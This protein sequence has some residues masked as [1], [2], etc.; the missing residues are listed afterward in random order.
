[1]LASAFLVGHNERYL[2]LQKVYKIKHTI[3]WESKIF[4]LVEFI[5]TLICKIT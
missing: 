1:M 5:L 3:D 2:I 4:A